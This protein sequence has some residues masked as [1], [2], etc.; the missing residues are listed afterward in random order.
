MLF[1]CGLGNPGNKYINSR[2]NVGFN[3]VSKIVKKY[4]LKNLKLNNRIE[5]YKGK[6]ENNIIF[7]LKPM[8]F[9][10]LSGKA[11]K[12]FFKYYK[13]STKNL[14]VIHDDLDLK[15]GK[16]KIKY[17][18]GNAGH[19]GLKSIDNEIGNNYY[20]LRIGIGHPESS[21]LVSK[22]VIQKFNIQEKQLID[23]VINFSLDNLEDLITN[24]ELFLTKINPLIKKI[25]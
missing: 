14:I 24:K 23:K 13:Y 3:F 19:N 16:I 21:E 20:R 7:V 18:G 25:L 8:E 5:I 10:N 11:L 4:H 2:H 9:M 6:I 22:Y 15:I 1:F 12:E 17:G